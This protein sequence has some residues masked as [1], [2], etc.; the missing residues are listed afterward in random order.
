LTEYAPDALL[1]AA[2]LEAQPFLKQDDR[3]PTWQGMYDRAV[4]AL[5][6]DDLKK[7]LDRSAQR[8]EA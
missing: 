4:Q 5:S 7:I 2:L 3:I 6:G 8:S 1:Y